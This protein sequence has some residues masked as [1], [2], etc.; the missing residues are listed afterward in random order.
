VV[1]LVISLAPIVT[2]LV[3]QTREDQQ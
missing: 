3:W 2:F 1:L